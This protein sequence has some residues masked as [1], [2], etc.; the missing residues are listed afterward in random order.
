[1]DF[2][3]KEL[4]VMALWSDTFDLVKAT[5]ENVKQGKVEL[6]ASLLKEM[7]AFLTHSM[8]YLEVW[9]DKQA[10]QDEAQKHREM[11]ESLVESNGYEGQ[12]GPRYK[13]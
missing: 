6:K 9:K 7:N 2:N 1:M 3:T 8:A 13:I 5:V 10:A 12:T 11:V 4:E